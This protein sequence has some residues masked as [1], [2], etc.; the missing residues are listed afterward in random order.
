MTR[1]FA[2]RSA[3]LTAAVLLSQV[4]ASRGLDVPIPAKVTV[5]K[6]GKIVKLVA[7]SATT[8]FVLPAHEVLPY[9]RQSPHPEVSEK[10]GIGLWWI[11]EG[12]ASIA[13]VP[14][15]S[16]LMKVPPSEFLDE[17]VIAIAHLGIA[18]FL[19]SFVRFG[20]GRSNREG[21]PA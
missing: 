20:K 6:P 1:A 5:V 12:R 18:G 19:M 9:D 3:L 21:S 15:R 7:R 14:V 2:R 8:P 10:R 11:A 13:V 16:A 4:Q 17:G